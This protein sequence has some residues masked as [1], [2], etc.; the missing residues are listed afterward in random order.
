MRYQAGFH[1]YSFDFIGG[2]LDIP[3]R[4][5]VDCCE[6]SKLFC[7]LRAF[8]GRDIVHHVVS[9]QEGKVITSRSL[10]ER[11]A[12]IH[13]FPFLI[14][15]TDKYGAPYACCSQNHHWIETSKDDS[16]DDHLPET[17]MYRPET[18]D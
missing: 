5:I 17:L 10:R 8:L 14:E 15:R 4:T 13:A 6:L 2:A 3:K 12:D 7:G 1:K 18:I 16:Y 9:I 11:P